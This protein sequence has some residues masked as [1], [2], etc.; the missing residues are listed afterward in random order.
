MYADVPLWLAI[1]FVVAG[2]A[3]L[4]WSSD[5]F[6]DGAA[7]L[8]TVLGISPFIIG[9]VV[10]GFGTSAPE[11]CVSALSSLSGHTDLSLGN[12][13]GSC[14]L[15]IA[16]ILGVAVLIFP[17]VVRP[18]V[19]LVAGPGLAALTAFS[20]AVLRDGT[21]SRVDAALLLGLFAV[22]LPLYCW[23]DQKFGA[24]QARRNDAPASGGG[25][26]AISLIKVVVGLALLVGSSHILVWGA[27]DLAKALGVSDLIGSNLFNTLAVVGLAC[28]LSPTSSFSPYVLTRDLPVLMGLSLSILV[29]GLNWRHWRWPGVIRRREAVVWSL[30]FVAYTALMLYQEV[31]R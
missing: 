16:L 12:A 30:S 7:K 25:G 13:Y 17:L 31:P 29:F 18:Q 10:I 15:N 9:M 8:A 2:L 4:A 14:S 19:T 27:V 23:Y 1:A 26:I 24:G 6:V 20:Y 3:V 28:V 5:V 21:C 22:L 11:L